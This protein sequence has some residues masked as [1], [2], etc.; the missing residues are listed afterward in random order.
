MKNDIP[1][2]HFHV[3]VPIRPLNADGTWGAKQHRVYNLDENGQ[4]TRKENGQWD[5]IATPTTDWG[6]PETLQKMA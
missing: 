4:R 5:F 2:P 6:R 3:L 1:N